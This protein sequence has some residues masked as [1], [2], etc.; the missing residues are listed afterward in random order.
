M[1]IGNA[2]TDGISHPGALVFST[3]EILEDKP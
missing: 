3:M 2:A 1:Q